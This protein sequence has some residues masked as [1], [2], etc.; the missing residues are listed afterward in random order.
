M[1]NIK[2]LKL[3][4]IGDTSV[5]KTCMFIRFVHGTF[6]EYI[7]TVFENHSYNMS[8]RGIPCVLSLWDTAG[9]E[10]YSRFRP[11]SYPQ[12]DCFL[13]CFSIANRKSFERCLDYWYP[14]I[15]LFCPEAPVIL[16]G[17]KIDLYDDHKLDRSNFVTYEEG[18]EMA[19]KIQAVEYIEISSLKNINIS[20]LFG[21]SSIISLNFE[22]KNK[23]HFKFPSN[24]NVESSQYSF[25]AKGDK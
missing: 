9:G 22:K 20:K 25:K 5:G 7:P 1:S 14:E 3:V 23:K 24:F 21:N 18:I 4:T 6:P 15:Q 13:L 10:D 17:T 11:L 2:R 19:K 8:Q 12:T 16:V